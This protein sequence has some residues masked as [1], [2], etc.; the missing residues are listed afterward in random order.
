MARCFWILRISLGEM[1]HRFRRASLRIRS[2]MT[3][4]RKR[5]S[6][7]SCDSPS[8]NVTVANRLTSFPPDESGPW[9][10]CAGK[11][12]PGVPSCTEWR[13]GVL[14]VGC[15]TQPHACSKTLCFG[16]DRFPGGASQA[17][18]GLHR[19]HS[20][21]L[22]P[23]LLPR[24]STNTHSTTCLAQ[25]KKIIADFQVIVKDREC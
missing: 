6:R 2:C 18:I 8:L 13:P 4:L 17:L 24:R 20:P 12:K 14:D 23:T 25:S 9:A 5:L 22:R 11:R 19:I 16:L 1:Y 10:P 3:S 7:L 21:W 15:Q